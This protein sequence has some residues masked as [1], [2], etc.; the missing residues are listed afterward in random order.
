MEQYKQGEQTR[1]IKRILVIPDLHAKP[2]L[3]YYDCVK[4]QREGEK[5][6][7][8]DFIID[9]AKDC[10]YAVFLGDVLDAKSN[11][12]L[13][14]KDLASFLKRFSSDDRD[15]NLILISGNHDAKSNGES[16]MDQ[17]QQL[18]NF[19]PWKI[20]TKNPQKLTFNDGIADYLTATFLPYTFKQQLQAKTKEE[21][22]KLL[23]DK[24]ESSDLLFHHHAILTEDNVEFMEN[25]DEI[26]LPLN[27]LRKKYK[28]ALGGHIHTNTFQPD[29]GFITVGSVFTSEV[30]ELDKYIVKITVDY[31]KY[32]PLD[33]TRKIT[34]ENIKLPTHPIVKV[35]NPTE[36]DIDKL[37]VNSI[38][39]FVVTDKIY[40]D[41]LTENKLSKF[42]GYTINEMYKR[43]RNK[44]NVSTNEN[45]LD[46]DLNGLLIE[47]SKVK[48][49]ELKA[50][51]E[52]LEMV[53][54]YK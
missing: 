27:E 21:G 50:L 43:E 6:Q 44:Q 4:D 16:A 17:F 40:K 51:Q 35:I 10:V 11:P 38:V 36:E 28:V 3:S 26:V 34:Y 7:I 18:E 42:Y 54:N 8:L 48:N 19:I 53:N 12:S 49:V 45:I 23:M 1:V 33:N 24:L 46:L 22:T 41:N 9:Q 32:D 37:D 31:N 30:G 39:K 29:N 15:T 52:G 14:L 2:H 5:Q 13:V 20:I 47:Y 25:F